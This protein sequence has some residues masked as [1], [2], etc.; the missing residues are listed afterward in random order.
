LAKH[1]TP[2]QLELVDTLARNPM[3]K[4]LKQDLRHRLL[5]AAEAG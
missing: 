1:K 4:V 5:S 3:G 2:E